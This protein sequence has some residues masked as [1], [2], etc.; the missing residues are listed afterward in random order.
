MLDSAVR[1]VPH[2]DEIHVPVFKELPSL[3]DEED[4]AGDIV[5]HDSEV[6]FEERGSTTR[7]QCF[8]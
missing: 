6:D 2:S 5:E 8:N 1:P 7:P 4:M 3:E